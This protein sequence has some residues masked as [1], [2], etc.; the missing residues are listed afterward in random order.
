MRPTRLIALAGIALASGAL[1]L[2]SLQTDA[3]V[4]E[5]LAAGQSVPWIWS[6]FSRSAQ[7][8][9]LAATGVAVTAA[10][11]PSQSRAAA[12]VVSLVAVAGALMAWQGRVDA[13]ESATLLESL[14]DRA[15][16]AGSIESSP[17]ASAGTGYLA[18]I[19]GWGAAA[20]AGVWEAAAPGRRGGDRV[21]VGKVPEH[22]MGGAAERGDR[23]DADEEAAAGGRSRFLELTFETGEDPSVEE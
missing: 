7:W 15:A 6:A 23:V 22:L 20:L 1:L 10:L 13:S 17:G 8:W 3:A 19:A 18:A 4:V 12:A 16:A 2:P 21:A 5:G 11:V 9:L 14:L